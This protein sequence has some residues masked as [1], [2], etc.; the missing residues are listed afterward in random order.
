MYI[1]QIKRERNGMTSQQRVYLLGITLKTKGY[2][3]YLLE[4]NRIVISRDVI[5]EENNTWDWNK[6][7]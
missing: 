1:V 6:Q 5:F 4:E 7:K 3:V 2:R